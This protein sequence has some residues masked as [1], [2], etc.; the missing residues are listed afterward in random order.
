MLVTA[1]S[2]S[3]LKGDD[4]HRCSSL[5]LDERLKQLGPA[6][7]IPFQAFFLEMWTA[8]ID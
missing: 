1:Q 7:A 5:P 2:I 8:P 3:E 4:A 6:T